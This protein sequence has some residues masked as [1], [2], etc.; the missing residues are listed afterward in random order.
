ME[1]DLTSGSRQVLTLEKQ[2]SEGSVTL[3]MLVQWH[4]AYEDSTSES[5][6][7]RERERDY[8]LGYQWT[9]AERATLAKRKQPCITDNR[10]LPKV[11]FLIGMEQAHRSMPKA[12]PR[13]PK[14][15]EDANAISDALRYV[16][17]DNR[18]DRTRS[19]CFDDFIVEGTCAVDV[20]VEKAKGGGYDIS[21]KRIPWN[22]YWHDPHST[23]EGFADSKY[24]GQFIWMDLA[25]AKEKWPKKA[26][27]LDGCFT[28]TSTTETFEDT[29]RERWT[30]TKRRRVR[31][32]ECWYKDGDKVVHTTFTKGITLEST[33]S[34]YKDTDGNPESGFVAGSC[35]IDRDGNRFGVVMNWMSMQ[36]EI[37]KRRSKA[38]HLMSV[39][40]TFGNAAVG[41]EQE[42]KVELAKADGHV[43][44]SGAAQFGKDFGVIPTSDMAAAHMELLGEAK[45][46]IDAVGVNAALAGKDQ[47]VQ[48]GRALIQRADQGTQELGP[49]FDGF[50]QFQLDVYRKVWNRIKQFWKEEK[51]IRVTD[52]EKNVR[53]VGLNAPLT[54]GDQMLEQMKKAGQQVTPQIRMQIEQDKAMQQVVGKKNKVAELDVDISILDVPATASLQAEQFEVLAQI[55]PQAGQMPPQLFEALIEASQLRNKEKILKALRGETEGKESPEVAQLKQQM[56]QMG[57]ELQKATQAAE[58][59]QGDIEIKRAELEIKSREVAI[60][61]QELQLKAMEA[62]R[63][64]G[65][66]G[67]AASAELDAQVAAARAELERQ[68]TAN[69]LRA[70]ELEKEAMHLEYERKLFD[71]QKQIAILQVQAAETNTVHAIDQAETALSHA[72]QQAQQAAKIETVKVS[73][74]DS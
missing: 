37:N 34:P 19:A 12:F 69:S 20:C 72:A 1:T 32:A 61:E 58:S 8:V 6:P 2:T 11:Q 59:K 60:K 55:A 26:S 67:Q 57:Q 66:D 7:E 71:A 22:R 39:R 10:L 40:Q 73:K 24:D 17:E 4:E 46:S 29:P 33:D 52:D 47:R 65:Q 51:W 64:M 35:Y 74:D 28:A 38:L 16:M 36:D 15:E 54:R 42:L 14:E 63:S 25:D 21:I 9:E 44:M 18:W 68:D 30:D 43:Q 49:V 62:Q 27:E 56:Q 45:Q 13:T 48:S 5:R 23:D 3:E 53:F 31:I 50:K 70:L 41:D